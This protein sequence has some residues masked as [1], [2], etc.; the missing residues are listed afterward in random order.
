MYR[1]ST[2]EFAAHGGV[3][4]MAFLPGFHIEYPGNIIRIK[5]IALT[6]DGVKWPSSGR[7]RTVVK[8][9]SENDPG[10]MNCALP[11]ATGRI[12]KDPDVEIEIEV[13]GNGKN[14]RYCFE[15]DTGVMKIFDQCGT[16]VEFSGARDN[17]KCFLF[18]G[19]GILNC[20]VVNGN[21]RIDEC[22]GFF[23]CASEDHVSGYADFSD[24]WEFT[25]A[26]SRSWWGDLYGS[27]ENSAVKDQYARAQLAA[28]IC[29]FGMFP[30]NTFYF[31]GNFS[32]WCRAARRLKLP[33]ILRSQLEKICRKGMAWNSHAKIFTGIDDGLWLP[34][35][36][37]REG[38]PLELDWRIALDC[39]SSCIAAVEMFDYCNELFDMN[40]LEKY[41]FNFM[42]GVMRVVELLIV[43]EN[44]KLHLPFGVMP[45]GRG[46]TLEGC[47][48]NVDRQL[49]YIH[50][51]NSRLQKASS[52]LGV[53]P[54][55]VWGDVAMRLP[56]ARGEWELPIS[57]PWG[58]SGAT[59]CSIIH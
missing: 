13:T 11:P 33:L 9:L 43:P 16:E 37:D 26:Q 4:P 3:A 6:P 18:R 53:A 45:G 10:L 22:S 24:E 57:E 1:K 30:E 46:K 58:K 54:D 36:S 5:G 7:L 35:R 29:Q 28:A 44:F 32:G 19:K 23:R 47:G 41:A 55:P 52:L 51:L 15:L 14:A 40:F 27:L 25:A 8:A 2:G 12:K 48:A 31:D 20:R 50:A 49:F 17:D 38:N 56:A 34:A 59:I 39:S 42:K 21:W